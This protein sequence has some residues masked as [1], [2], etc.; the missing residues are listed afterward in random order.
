MDQNREKVSLL[1]ALLAVG[2]SHYHGPG[3]FHKQEFLI[4]AGS[5]NEKSEITANICESHKF[6]IARCS[7]GGRNDVLFFSWIVLPS[8][9]VILL[10]E[11]ESAAAET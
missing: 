11:C 7:A 5:I 4:L 8:N 3:L 9:R 1:I 10:L 2:R 6:E